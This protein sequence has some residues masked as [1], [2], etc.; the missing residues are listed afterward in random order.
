MVH[1]YHCIDWFGGHTGIDAVWLMTDTVRCER[2]LGS[3]IEFHNQNSIC[4]DCITE[5]LINSVEELTA[6][7]NRSLNIRRC[8]QCCVWND[9]NWWWFSDRLN[10]WVCYACGMGRRAEQN[11]IDKKWR[12]ENDTKNGS[13]S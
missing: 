12:K 5:E 1:S 2:C 8:P 10:N 6:D 7:S 13:K 4:P 3:Q 11:R 9:I